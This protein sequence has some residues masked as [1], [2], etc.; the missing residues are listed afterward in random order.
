MDSS[1]AA[2]WKEAV[3]VETAAPWSDGHCGS[4]DVTIA[5]ITPSLP[6]SAPFV[7]EAMLWLTSLKLA[8]PHSQVP[9]T[10]VGFLVAVSQAMDLGRREKG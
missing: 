6:L 7:S 5:T 4:N 3:W 8:R 1:Q 2:E 10:R 9:E